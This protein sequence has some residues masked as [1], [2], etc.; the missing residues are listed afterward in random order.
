MQWAV[1]AEVRLGALRMVNARRWLRYILA[2]TL[3]LFGSLLLYGFAVLLLGWL[4]VNR[5]YRAPQQGITLYLRSNG[6]HTDLV[7]PAV[8]QQ[9]DWRREFPGVDFAPPLKPLVDQTRLALAADI[10]PDRNPLAT[11]V[12]IGWGDQGFYFDMPNWSD[13][14]AAVALRAVTGTG[15]SVMHAEYLPT[16]AASPRIRKLVVTPETYARLIS[17]VRSALVRDAN[18]ARHPYPGRGYTVHDTF[19]AAKGSF[20][21]VSTCNEW[22]RRALASAGVRVP[23]WA[24]FPYALFGELA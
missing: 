17:H 4:T 6:I 2:L 10:A 1:E 12:A 7:L 24:P 21:A 3:A 15:Q 13:L 5:D 20:S 11:H 8:T 9:I 19:Y 22:V 16:P 23:L 18:G 14:S